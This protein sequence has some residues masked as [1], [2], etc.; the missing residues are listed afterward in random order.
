MAKL[1]IKVITPEKTVFENENIDSITIPTIEGEIT[2]LP[3]HIPF[4]SKVSPG[5]IVIR[6]DKKEYSLVSVDGFVKVS[7]DNTVSILSDYAIRS[8]N[9]EIAKVLEAKKKAENA[10]KD[11]ESARDFA[12]AEADLRRI[13]LELKIAQRRKSSVYSE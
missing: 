8:E 7:K 12:I 5:E 4:F 11:K 9:I 10:L 2:V 13:L 6:T 3:G 1:K